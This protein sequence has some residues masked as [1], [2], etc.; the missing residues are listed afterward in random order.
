[1]LISASVLT[2]RSVTTCNAPDTSLP[3]TGYSVQKL[4]EWLAAEGRSVQALDDYA[5]LAKLRYDVGI[6][7]HI[8]AIREHASLPP[9]HLSTI[10]IILANA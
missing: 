9:L 5:R 1:M 7:N 6:R 2:I 4:R 8:A 10:E 3:H